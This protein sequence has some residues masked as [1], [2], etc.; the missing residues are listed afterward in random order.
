MSLARDQ[1]SELRSLRGALWGARIL[2]HEL[3]RDGDGVYLN[4][5]G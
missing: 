2:L 1:S 3:P 4:D 5:E